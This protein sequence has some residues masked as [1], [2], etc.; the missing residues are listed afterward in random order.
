MIFTP[1]K[2]AKLVILLMVLFINTYLVLGFTGTVSSFYG[3]SNPFNIT[4][5]GNENNTQYL[6]IPQYSYI[7][8]VTFTSQ[9][10]EGNITLLYK[11]NYLNM[12]DTCQ[13]EIAFEPKVGY[14]FYVCANDGVTDY[15]CKT[16]LSEMNKSNTFSTESF[17]YN[18]SKQ[19]RLKF[20]WKR[21]QYKDMNNSALNGYNDSGTFSNSIVND[22]CTE[23][24]TVDNRIGCYDD[25]ACTTNFGGGQYAVGYRF[26]PYYYH[27]A[28]TPSDGRIYE[29]YTRIGGSNAIL[30]TPINSSSCTL[31]DSYYF[32][33]DCD[34]ESCI[35][36][37][38]SN[39]I[40]NLN[41]YYQCTLGTPSSLPSSLCTYSNDTTTYSNYFNLT[42]INTSFSS[43]LLSSGNISFL[44]DKKYFISNT[45]QINLSNINSVNISQLNSILSSNCTCTNCSIIGYNCNIPFNFHSDSAGILSVNLTNATYSYGIDFCNN[46]LGIPSNRSIL[47]ISFYDENSLTNISVNVSGTI[48]LNESNYTFSEVNVGNLYMCIYPSWGNTTIS[49]YFQYVNAVSERYYISNLVLTNDAQKINMYNFVSSTGLSLL[50]SILYNYYYTLTP[51][52][53]GKLQRY[54]PS[55]NSWITVQVDKSDN[56]GQLLYYVYQNNVDY[57]FIWEL[58]GITQEQT[59]PMKFICGVGVDCEQSFTLTNP[60]SVDRYSGMTWYPSYNNATGIYSITWFDTNNQVSSVRLVVQQMASNG[61]IIICDTTTSSSSG[62][63]TCD[64]TGYN[65]VILIQATRT[66]SPAV[67]FFSDQI[68]KS[69]KELAEAFSNKGMTNDG[70]F[71][72]FLLSL[73][74]ASL[75]F[76]NPILSIVGLLF[77][78]VIIYFLGIM[79]IFT[80]VILTS[81]I[82][83]GLIVALMVKR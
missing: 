83:L 46:S 43:I 9:L 81:I 64:T 51:G 21:I 35:C 71:L 62:T 22:S 57:R 80:G 72:S 69:I 38:H 7:N 42:N 20:N 34:W 15:G 53:I 1:P 78:F 13:G 31:I 54:Y 37:G 29:T 32:S 25:A 28:P 63:I 55:L 44:S 49:A 33:D 3:Q 59:D 76:I 73:G 75:G 6:S 36:P 77:S 58:N 66:A 2:S 56:Q 18:A 24:R 26:G 68:D 16:Y 70:V 65:G 50:K 40:S 23:N 27:Y 30:S 4:F 11:P 41:K 47:N 52:Y 67:F 61:E 5:S 48:Q 10:I 14:E 17:L 12:T 82:C 74:I 19:Y 8:N 79:T 45:N 60:A 39:Y